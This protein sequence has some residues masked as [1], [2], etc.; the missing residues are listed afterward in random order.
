MIKANEMLNFST[1]FA[2]ELYMFRP[3]LLST[4]RMADGNITS[5]TN[6]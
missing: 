6:T 5:M 4:I 2:E 3:D 1:L